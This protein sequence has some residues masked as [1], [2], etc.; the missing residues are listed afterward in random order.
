MCSSRRNARISRNYH[1]SGKEPIEL[2]PI[3]STT[4][5][6]RPL[7]ESGHSGGTPGATYFLRE[8]MRIKNALQQTPNNLVNS[9]NNYY[10]SPTI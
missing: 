2:E 8:K 9:I 1:T 3:R 4:K 6:L 10:Y 7:G 5:Q